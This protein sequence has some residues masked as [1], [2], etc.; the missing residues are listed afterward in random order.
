MDKLTITDTPR[1]PSTLAHVLLPCPSCRRMTEPLEAP[2]TPIH[3]SLLRC[4][5]CHAY[6]KWRKWPRDQSGR[7]LPRPSF[8]EPH[9]CIAETRP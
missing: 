1:I 8:L 9:N 6:L 3:Y 5:T 2:G 4:G 7:K